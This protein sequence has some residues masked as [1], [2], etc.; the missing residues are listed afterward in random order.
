MILDTFL[1]MQSRDVID[2]AMESLRCPGNLCARFAPPIFDKS[3]RGDIDSVLHDFCE[4]CSLQA[5]QEPLCNFCSH[6]RLRHLAICLRQRLTGLLV[7]LN[8]PKNSNAIS[9]IMS[10]TGCALCSL[11]ANAIHSYCIMSQK[12]EEDVRANTAVTL[13]LAQEYGSFRLILNLDTVDGHEEMEIACREPSKEWV[14]YIRPYVSWPIVQQWIHRCTDDHHCVRL[15]HS[16]V[17]QGFRL[18]DVDKQRLVSDFLPDSELGYDIKFVA[19]SYVWGKPDTSRINALLR[20]NKHELTAPGGLGKLSLPKAIKDA[21]TVCRQLNQRFLWVDRL[22]IQQDDNGPEKQAQINAMGKIYSSAEFTIIHAS[23]INM[24]DPIAGVTTTRE[25]FQSRTVVCGVELISGYPDIKVPLE[26]SRW[27][28]RGWTYQEATLSRRKLFFTPFE[29]W[30]ECSDSD[31]PYQREDQCSRPTFGRHFSHLSKQGMID[32]GIDGF[33]D[34]TAKFDDFV[35][36]LESYTAKSLTHQSDILD[37]FLGILTELYEGDLSIYGLPEADFD[38]ALLWY[39]KIRRRPTVVALGFP[40]WSWTS[41]IGTVTNPIIYLGLNGFLGTLVQWY[42]Q[43][44]NGELKR[45]KSKNSLHPGLNLDSRAQTLLLVAWLKGCVEP[46]V[47]EDVKQE[48]EKCSTSCESS[49]WTNLRLT[50]RIWAHTE[51]PEGCATCQSQI[52]QRWPCLEAIWKDIERTRCS[53]FEDTQYF[54]TGSQEEDRQLIAQ[55]HPGIL[56]T[57]AQT[58]CLKASITQGS[59]IGKM[60]LTDSGGRRIGEVQP[61]SELAGNTKSEEALHAASFECM[62]I[63]LFSSFSVDKERTQPAVNVL[64]IHREEGS[65]FWRRIA[66]G[67][68][69]LVDWIKADPVF[70]TIGLE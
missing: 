2:G 6:I 34:D 40:S 69:Y 12:R 53:A 42:Y 45:V 62:G 14:P 11:L 61:E 9:R 30:F 8:S 51:R 31:A 46:T 55:L 56:L 50:E 47:P 44:R 17:P 24:D 16:T 41:V 29:L 25:V 18:I 63:S 19:L 21:I 15:E 60:Y 10:N 35:R 70:K 52:A 33:I 39:C 3:E 32:H 57:R 27:N 23:G 48:L 20:S 54:T 22:C 4:N 28:E 65:L 26:V 38:Q 66:V 58:T 59:K 36:H 68:L 13:W 43:D 67:W 5:E 7:H 64:F 1:P 37:A 49:D